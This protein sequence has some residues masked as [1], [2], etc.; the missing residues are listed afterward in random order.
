MFELF[1]HYPDNNVGG[2][3]PAQWAYL[4]RHIAEN[5]KKTQTY[6]RDSSV[7]IN[8]DHI[9]V[10]LLYG[11]NVSM[12][13]EPRDYYEEIRR[14]GF[15]LAMTLGITSPVYRG[16]VQPSAFYGRNCVE[17][18][19]ATDETFDPDHAY[20]NWKELEA[21][22]PLVHPFTSM[23]L[24]LPYSIDSS[25]EFGIA[26]IAINIPMLAMQYKGF[27]DAQAANQDIDGVTS[28]LARY[29]WPNM[30]SQHLDQAWFNR[31]NARLFKQPIKTHLGKKL[32]FAL[33][34]LE[35][36]FMSCEKAVLDNLSLLVKPTFEAQ[37]KTIPSLN[38]DNFY[39]TLILPDIATTNQ[40]TW[41]LDCARLKHL[42][43]LLR[44]GREDSYSSSKEWII[45]AVRSLQYNNV[46]SFMKQLLPPEAYLLQSILVNQLLT[47]YQK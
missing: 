20:E 2:Q 24:P 12:N 39:E 22:R 18:L 4:S 7:F 25:S 21:V 28:F 45:Q 26:V 27:V 13:M 8:S 17:I 29:V 3:R 34:E 16:R 11:L 41:A 30:L 1:E 44:C 14:R 40:V 15:T 35:R 38:A 37:L 31:L 9:L 47:F 10:D 36:Y 42:V 19:I 32:P 23:D 43:F 33:L 46:D 6:F 5:I